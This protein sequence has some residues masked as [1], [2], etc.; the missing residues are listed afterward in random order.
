MAD[1]VDGGRIA[2]DGLQQRIQADD[3]SARIAG[4]GLV[5]PGRD[6]GARAR[7]AE[8]RSVSSA[9]RAAFEHLVGDEGGVVIGFGQMRWRTICET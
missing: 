6:R 8:L 3:R 4:D 7:R 9:L 2:D 5:Q 1:V